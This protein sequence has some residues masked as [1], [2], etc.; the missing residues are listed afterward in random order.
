[1]RTPYNG[2]RLVKWLHTGF[3]L[4]HT[5]VRI[6]HRALKV[7]GNSSTAEPSIVAREVVGANPIFH[8]VLGYSPVIR[9][10]AL[11]RNTEV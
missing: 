7:C 8:S 6:P 4:Q 9:R 1:M 3:R 10:S 2:A 11:D 5:R